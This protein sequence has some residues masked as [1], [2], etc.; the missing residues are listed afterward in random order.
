MDKTTAQILHLLNEG[1]GKSGC[2]MV[3]FPLQDTVEIQEWVA[4]N[5][6]QEVIITPERETHITVLFGV[7]P[8][9][10]LSKITEFLN[11]V[12][13]VVAKLKSINL[14][15]NP[16]Q[17]VLKIDVES[18]QLMEVNRRLREFLGPDGVE[19]ETYPYNPHVT[20]A[21]TKPGSMKHMAGNDRFNGYVYLLKDMI[22]SEPGSVRKHEFALSN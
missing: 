15:C 17:D 12:P 19:P 1:V 14:F 3:R 10:P 16:E 18:P 13:M 6:P 21:Y 9:V 8:T 4:E 5:V 11:S 20:L 7:K 22:Y 2:L